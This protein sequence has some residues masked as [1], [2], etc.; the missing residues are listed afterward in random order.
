M[1]KV[2][3]LPV[4]VDFHTT[5]RFHSNNNYDN[6][7]N[8]LCSQVQ[9][10]LDISKN[11]IPFQDRPISAIAAFECGELLD[12]DKKGRKEICNLVHN[13]KHIVNTSFPSDKKRITFWS[14]LQKHAFSLAPSGLFFLLSFVI[15]IIIRYYYSFLLFVIIIRYYY[16]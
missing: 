6:A 11:Q 16:Y 14:E 7:H 10:Y 3:P 2:I 5:T 15:I 9:E 8:L 4:G 1:N 12:E 13:N